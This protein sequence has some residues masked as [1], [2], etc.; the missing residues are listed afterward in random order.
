MWMW[1]E[2]EQGEQQGE[3]QGE[4]RGEQRGEQWGKADVVAGSEL[5]GPQ[6]RPHGAAACASSARQ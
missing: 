3:E 6:S 5:W 2:E 4:Q 1:R